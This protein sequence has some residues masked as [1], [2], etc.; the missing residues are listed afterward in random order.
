MSLDKSSQ[1]LSGLQEAITD[2]IETLNES[3]ARSPTKADISHDDLLNRYVVRI[4][5]K[6]SGEVVR[7]IPSEELLKFARYLEKLRGILFDTKV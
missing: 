7:E 2:A 1:H 6:Q 5:D 3:L 4:S